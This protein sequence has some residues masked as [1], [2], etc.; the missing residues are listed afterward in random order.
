MATFNQRPRLLSSQAATEASADNSGDLNSK[1]EFQADTRKLLE[2]VAKSLYSDNEV[3]IRELISNSCDALEKF[4]YKTSTDS[5]QKYQNIDRSLEIKIET[6]RTL[7][8]ITIQDSGIGMTKAELFNNLGT[9]ARSGSKQFLEEI[10]HADGS[11]PASNIIG[12]FGVGFY[13]SFTVAREVQ[14]FTRSSEEGSVGYCWTSDGVS[15]YEI[16]EQDNLDF[17]TKI[18]IHLKPECRKFAE[19]DT[20]K[21]K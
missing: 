11:A 14:V 4:R 18:V 12:Q 16:K 19:E 6:N 15:S 9:I 21:G 1:H 5:Q 3:F 2:I 17:G 8:T 13:S 7:N 10:K 20:V